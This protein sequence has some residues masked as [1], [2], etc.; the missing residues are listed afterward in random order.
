MKLRD[1]FDK[2][3]MTWCYIGGEY[4]DE[5][6]VYADFDDDRAETTSVFVGDNDRLDDMLQAE[7][8]ELDER[9]YGYAVDRLEGR[10]AQ[11][12]DRGA[13]RREIA[14]EARQEA[15]RQGREQR[16]FK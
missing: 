14:Q 5:V 9:V 4:H 8:E 10:R 12:E 1:C 11:A 15:L 3:F 6:R 7:V 2:P 16:G 13:W